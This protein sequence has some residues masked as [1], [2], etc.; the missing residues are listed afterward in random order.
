MGLFTHRKS[1][2]AIPPSPPR[3]R[4]QLENLEE[5]CVPSTAGYLDPTFGSPN[6]YVLDSPN[7]GGGGA[8]VVVQPDGKIVVAGVAANSRGQGSLA[9][10]RYNANG[11]L[12]STFGTGGVALTTIGKLAQELHAVALQPDGKI[13]VAGSVAL[14]FTAFPHDWEWVLERYNPNG[15]LDTTFGTGGHPTGVVQLNLTPSDDEVVALQIQP[16]DGKIVV[17]GINSG[18]EIAIARFNTNGSSDSTFGSG[19]FV[20]DNPAAFQSL[21]LGPS[22]LALQPDHRIV[23]A[24]ST[25]DPSS[26][27]WRFLVQRYNSDGSLDTSFNGTGF[28][29]A[30]PSNATTTSGGGIVLQP[31]GSIVMAGSV[32]FTNSSQAAVI[33]FS[34][35][36]IL[37]PTFGGNGWAYVSGL[38]YPTGI[39]I[40]PN[41]GG[42]FDVVGVHTDTTT[43]THTHSSA[44]ARLQANGS[45]DTSFGANAG[46]SSYFAPN[47]S[48]NAYLEGGIALQ[49]DGNIVTT[50][51]VVGQVNQPSQ[52][53]VV[54]RYSGATSPQI[55]SFSASPNPVTAGSNVTLTASNVVDPNPNGSITQ[56]AFYVQ[57]NGTNTLLGYGTQTG[58]GVWTFTFTVSLAPGT[59]TLFAQAEDNYGLFSD[60]CASALTVQ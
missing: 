28:V 50:G 14:S 20:I 19:G 13:V 58:P 12:D 7:L 9:V 6:G 49:S 56:V 29:S 55:G 23:A 41:T 2:R 10:F 43:S 59:Y 45:L 44:V 25:L 30:T 18:S 15:T 60:P 31:D 16:W 8:A 27:Y 17:Q 1:R 53:L 35:T 52:V 34:S 48:P 4:P 21:G 46:L 3:F 5:R 47:G 22:G 32:G 11:T 40:H 38:S 37:D 42:E 54:A 36:G 39:V 51:R 24:G 33:R 57:V 26:H